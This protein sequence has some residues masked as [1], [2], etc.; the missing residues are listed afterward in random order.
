MIDTNFIQYI[1]NNNSNN[2]TESTPLV[3]REKTG[4]SVTNNYEILLYLSYYIKKLN[5]SLY[6][7]IKG[8]NTKANDLLKKSNEES[9]IVHFDKQNIKDDAISVVYMNNMVS[10]NISSLI[11][12]LIN[13]TIAFKNIS[14]IQNKIV[15]FEKNLDNILLKEE[16]D[17]LIRLGLNQ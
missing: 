6:D 15:S 10:L 8:I 3:L 7:Y 1:K 2:Y 14:C 16:R 9:K 13:G 11:V 17:C 4:T 5:I 12:N